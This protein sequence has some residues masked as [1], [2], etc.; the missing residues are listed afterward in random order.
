MTA[1]DEH[2]PG[3]PCT[4]RRCGRRPMQSLGML[5]N[6]LVREEW[7]GHPGRVLEEAGDGSY[8]DQLPDAEIRLVAAS[9]ALNAGEA[10]RALQLLSE[11]PTGSGDTAAVGEA[12]RHLARIVDRNWFPGGGAAVLEPGDAERLTVDPPRPTTPAGLLLIV[13]ATRLVGALPSW[14][15]FVAG[16]DEGTGLA[17]RMAEAV[18]NDLLR[19]GRPVAVA[20]AELLLADLLARAGHDAQAQEQL[21]RARAAYEA[22]QDPV[23]VAACVLTSG[24]WMAA[25]GSSPEL[26]A[27]QLE[28]GLA[29]TGRVGDAAGA[30][31]LWAAAERAFA[32][33]GAPRGVAA[34]RIRRAWLAAAAGRADEALPL[35]DQAR[36]LADQAGDSGLVRLIDVHGAL[37]RIDAGDPA[38]VQDVGA[39]VGRWAT[40]VGSTSFARGLARLC[41]ARSRRWRDEDVL[42][43]RQ[44][45]LLAEAINA[46]LGVTTESAMLRS[47]QANRYM[48]VNYRRA[49]LVLTLSELE[50]ARSHPAVRSELGWAALVDRTAT[51]NRDAHALRDGDALARVG[52]LAAWLRDGAA[53]G[54]LEATFRPFLDDVIAEG[55]VFIPL[56]RGVAARAAGDLATAQR[57]LDAALAAAPAVGPLPTAVVLGT[58]RRFDDAAAHLAP[59]L[60]AGLPLDLTVRLLVRLKRFDEALAAL[61]RLAAQGG[62]PEG[63]QPWEGPAVHAEALLGAGNPGAAAPR[64]AEAI[65]AFEHH[66]TALALDVFRTTASDDL[67][68]AGLYTTAVSAHA[69]LAGAEPSR[70]VD[71]ARAFELSDR[72]RASALTDL[73]EAGRL[74]RVDQHVL[75]AVRSWQRAGAELARTIEQVAALGPTAHTPPGHIHRTVRAAERSLDEAEAAVAVTAPRL[76]AGRR[77]LPVT[78]SLAEV[79][80]RLGPGSLLLQYHAFN[81]E[82]IGWAVTNEDA[83]VV[84]Q[85]RE[86]PLLTAAVRQFHRAVAARSSTVAAR[87]A[88]AHRFAAALLGPF[89][90]ELQTFRRVVF[91]PHGPLA[92]LPFH[93]LPH[94]DD[95]LAATHAVSYLP[96]ASMAP[97]V[98]GRIRPDAPTLVL[99][100]PAFS[101]QRGLPRLPGAR[102]EALAVAR[103]RRTDPLI[104]SGATREALLDALPSARL[105]YLATHGILRE[106]APYSAELVLAGDGSLT[107]PDLMGLGVT[108]DLAILSACDSGRGQATAAGDLIGLTRALIAAGARELVVSLWPVD[109]RTAC[110]TMVAL[111][112]ELMTT[113][114]TGQALA[115]AQRRLRALSQGAA[116][117]WYRS[118]RTDPEAPLAGHVR[119]SR[120]L[121][122]T[123]PEATTS[124]D[125]P[126]HPFFWAP[127]VHIGTS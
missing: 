72:S 69:A 88:L 51:A 11:L 13:V 101:T 90:D 112:E 35:L 48:Q 39:A 10:K 92:V 45:V 28:D 76:L 8:R 71:L 46:P 115:A 113:E 95:V 32:A 7:R 52:E 42:R 17:L 86:T 15:R 22:A 124:A 70:S 111:H 96:A 19:F 41:L 104:G 25:P 68:V 21:G 108:V 99:G 66:L 85:Q 118:L 23:G 60:E 106:G 20:P 27:E 26:L 77:R 94:D 18:R 119:S 109:D 89:A 74:T 122:G 97:R 61:E 110:L 31:G 9:A 53:G 14:R 107:V 34:V 84:L 64:A 123:A 24:D 38:D 54:D 63:D 81:D 1:A 36:S 80:S 67:D 33:A 114:S 103:L 57:Q 62:F 78:P 43:S 125:D 5:L 82:L 30:L 56:Y 37:A 59:L 93:L 105:L 98:P 75:G 116:D 73:V 121:G 16:G 2:R 83:R 55:A 29:A 91:V 65:A 4:L 102:D 58:M 49:A 50:D 126:A 40:S 79:Q 100:D 117:E 127:F 44:A 12:L 47:A 120:D 6:L 87:D 3:R